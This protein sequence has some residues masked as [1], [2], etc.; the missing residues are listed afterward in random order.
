MK[1][2]AIAT[3]SLADY[4][5]VINDEHRAAYGCAQEAI[6]HARIAGEHLLKAKAALKHGEWLPWLAANVEVSESQAQRYMK[7][8]QNWT[9]ISRAGGM[10]ELTLRGAL[11]SLSKSTPK[12]AAGPTKSRTVRDLPT[13]PDGEPKSRTATDLPAL[14]EPEPQKPA[15]PIKPAEVEQVVEENKE[16]SA[17]ISEMA[18]DQ[19]AM[20]EELEFLRRVEDAGDKL[21]E[22]LDEVKRLQGI[23]RALEERL[24]GMQNEKNT[25]ARWVKFWKSKYEKLSKKT[26]L[27]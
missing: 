12:Q 18:E 6:E 14:P 16:L 25:E 2:N 24:K 4:A 10:S 21:K 15:K 23:N 26:G 20:R 1:K 22:A 7:V 27:E 11:D 3:A 9:A 8:A 5:A 13:E 17:R 19:S